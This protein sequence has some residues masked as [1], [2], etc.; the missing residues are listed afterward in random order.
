MK[1]SD[2]VI[3]LINGKEY[4]AEVTAQDENLQLVYLSLNEA[5]DGETELAVNETQIIR[6]VE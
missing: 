2:T 3:A 1:I 4:T 6:I 5:I